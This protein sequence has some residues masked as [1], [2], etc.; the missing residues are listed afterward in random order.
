[1]FTSI[2]IFSQLFHSSGISVI[3]YLVAVFLLVSVSLILI[4][5]Y[6]YS[7]SFK[8]IFDSIKDDHGNP[9][10]TDEID[11][12]RRGNLSLNMKTGR[13]GML[14]LFVA[15]WLFVAA[16]TLASY[17]EDWSSQNLFFLLFSWEVLS[18]FIHFIT[19]A[20]AVTGAA[21][22]FGFFYREGGKKNLDDAYKEFVRN[23]S[24]KIT[25]AAALFQPLFLLIN[26]LA[27]PGDAL[28]ASVFSYSFI[29]LI[30][31]F[32]AYH[33]LYDMLKNSYEISGMFLSPSSRFSL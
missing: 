14:L 3:P 26:L 11:K 29:A 31:L 17:P 18:R 20:F 25:F 10:L 24:I 12:F 15:L 27:L 6:K 23:I 2:L 19:A 21:I 9:S 7:F 30:L 5:T 1:V 13:Y 32:L 8:N 4:Y 28:S 22:L 33:Y 16:I